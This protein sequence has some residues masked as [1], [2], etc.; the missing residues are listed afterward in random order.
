MKDI[1]TKIYSKLVYYDIRCQYLVAECNTGFGDEQYTKNALEHYLKKIK[2]I[3]RD[4]KLYP[5]V[6]LKLLSVKK[7]IENDLWIFRGFR[8]R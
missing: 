4:Y 6:K 5:S 7:G 8:K 1:Q 3:E 2:E